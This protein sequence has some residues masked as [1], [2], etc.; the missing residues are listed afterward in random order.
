[1]RPSLSGGWGLILGNCVLASFMGMCFHISHGYRQRFNVSETS[2]P[3][4]PCDS[5]VPAA[6]PF[7]IHRREPRRY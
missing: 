3:F 6:S 4:D 5:I 7:G 1:M 2:P